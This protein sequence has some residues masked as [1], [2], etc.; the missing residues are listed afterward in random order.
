MIAYRPWLAGAQ[1]AWVAWG[2]TLVLTAIALGLGVLARPADPLFADAQFPWPLLGPLLAALRYGFA[3]ALVSGLFLGIGAQA[4]LA[5]AEVGGLETSLLPIVGLLCCALIAGEFRDAWQRRLTRLQRVAE[6]S[7]GRLGEFTRAYHLLRLSHDQLEQ[8]LAGTSHSLR[9]ALLDLRRSLGP[10]LRNGDG[11]DAFGGRGD[12]VLAMFAEYGALGTATLHGVAG[13]PPQL[14]DVC[15][16]LGE[17]AAVAADDHLVTLALETGDLVSVAVA[18]RDHGLDP[19]QTS[20]VA[21][22]P[23]TTAGGAVRGLIAVQF[24]PFFAVTRANLTLLAV[25]AGNV[26]DALAAAERAGSA[27]PWIQ[28]FQNELMRLRAD[29]RRHG[30]TAVVAALRFPP[31]QLVH[32]VASLLEQ[33]RRGLD[34]LWVFDDAD[35]PRVVVLLPLTDGSG[36]A[37]YEHRLE[38]M[39][40]ETFGSNREALGLALHHIVIDRWISDARLHNFLVETVGLDRDQIVV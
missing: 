29:A 40:A 16:A 2:E 4:W 8:R 25:V 28:G 31:G 14:G 7:E 6:Y 35:E 11:S 12:D 1:R 5:A 24:M 19:G 3:H 30:L 20:L 22:I 39:L 10:R 15:A 32:E 26:A 23:L 18:E 33:R 21:A 9:E 37:G 13:D 38:R 17:P 36:F 27:D 34:L